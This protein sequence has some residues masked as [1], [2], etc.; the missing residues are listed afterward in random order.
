L[1]ADDLLTDIA[2]ADAGA[3]ENEIYDS[4]LKLGMVQ[5]VIAVAQAKMRT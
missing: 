4:K 1:L 5:R 2:L 3:I